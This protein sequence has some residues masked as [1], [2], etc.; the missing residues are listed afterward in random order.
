MHPRTVVAGQGLSLSAIAILDRSHSVAKPGFSRWLVPP[1]ALAF[2]CPS[3]RPTRSAS[4]TCRCRSSSASRIRARRLEA[5][6][7]RLDLHDRDRLSRRLGGGV[8]PLARGR[9]AAPRDVRVGP[10]L[11]RRVSGRAP[12]RRDA[13]ALARLSS[14]TACSAASGSGSATSRRS[15]RSSSGSPIA[16]AWRPAWRSWASAAAR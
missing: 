14:A 8:R 3:A 15:R 4:S 2:I 5:H 10:V 11:R 12:R 6:R 1:A 16:R 7:P 13:P 9:R